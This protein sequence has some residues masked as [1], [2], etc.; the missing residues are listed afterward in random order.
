MNKYKIIDN[1]KEVYIV[2]AENALKDITKWME[3]YHN[4]EVIDLYADGEF[5]Y[6]ARLRIIKL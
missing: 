4:P 2:V 5:E 1:G 3:V 6:I